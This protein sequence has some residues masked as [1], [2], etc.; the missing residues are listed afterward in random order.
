MEKNYY[1]ETVEKIDLLIKEQKYEDAYALVVTELSLPYVPET[2]WPLFL[3]QKSQILEIFKNTNQKN[4]KF[5]VEEIFKII[6]NDEQIL[7]AYALNYLENIALV[8]FLFNVNNIFINPKIKTEIKGLIYEICVKQKINK[9]F[10]INDKKIN[11][12]KYGSIGQHNNYHYIWNLI[13]KKCNKD[14]SMINVAYFI[15]N[16]YLLCNFVNWLTG[17]LKS[18]FEN[19]IFELTL[20]YLNQITEKDLSQ[21][22]KEIM[23][24]IR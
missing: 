23:E 11:P 10:L 14:Q 13:N 3:K 18:T 19:A 21:K 5:S 8:N 22:A 17:E 20:L 1:D 16:K 7:M 9:D 12:T 15:Y 2:Y 24:F 6:E 4:L